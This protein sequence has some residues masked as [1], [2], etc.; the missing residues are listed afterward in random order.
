MRSVASHNERETKNIGWYQRGGTGT[1]LRNQLAAFV[2]DSGSDNTGLGRWS[3]Y[4]VEG[5]PGHQTYV[6]TT[7]AP[8]DNIEVGDYT[9]HK[10]QERYIQEKGLKQIQKRY[11]RRTS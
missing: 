7:Y 6:I 11:F 1:I 5:E 8:C 10:Q 2:I 9:V 4:L 3:W